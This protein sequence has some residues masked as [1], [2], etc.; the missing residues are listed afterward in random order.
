MDKNVNHRSPGRPRS[1]RADDAI[2]A[3]AINLLIDRGVGETSIEKVAQQAG[4]TRATVYRRFAD[5][6]ELLVRA[7]GW[8]YRDQEPGLLEW[9][10][11]DSMLTDWGD[12]LSQTRHRRLLRRLYGSV[13]D[14]PELLQSYGKA[15]GEQRTRAV[16]TVLQR[17][18]DKGQFPAD[19]DVDIILQ[20]LSGAILYHLGTYPDNVSADDI[21]AYLAALLRQ[22]GH[23]PAQSRPSKP[24]KSPAR[25]TR[26]HQTAARST[27]S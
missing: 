25:K 8:E 22:A 23:Q 10:D 2:L 9:A 5:K 27:P 17:A 12:Y 7:I 24:A 14:Y 11:I 4:V 1:E 6:T 13:D 18:V 21:K 19:S 26:G 20:M 16:H 3:A 15:S